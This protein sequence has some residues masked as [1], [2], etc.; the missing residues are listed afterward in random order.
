MSE[1]MARQLG[2][3]IGRFLE[4]DTTIVTRGIKKFMRVRVCLNVRSP[5]KRRKFILYGQNN[6]TNATFQY[7]K[8]SLLCFMCERLEHGDSFCLLRL[9]T[10]AQEMTL[11]CDLSIRAPPKRT[12]QNERRWLRAEPKNMVK[13][14]VKVEAR[15]RDL[16]EK[17]SNDKTPKM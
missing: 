14:G 8:L 2:N 12:M 7:E 15:R 13:S 5:L 16:M 9:T 1:G 3:F 6:S 10:G 17:T 4:Y 11:G